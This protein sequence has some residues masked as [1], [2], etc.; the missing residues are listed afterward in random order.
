MVEALNQLETPSV[1]VVINKKRYEQQQELESPAENNGICMKKMG[2]VTCVFADR[3]PQSQFR[4]L[5]DECTLPSIVGGANS[6]NEFQI[7]N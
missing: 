4:A 2:N 7:R 5:I 3:L 1:C 6:A